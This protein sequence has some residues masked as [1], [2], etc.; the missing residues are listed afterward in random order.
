VVVVLGLGPA[1]VPVPVQAQVPA[2]GQALAQA[3]VLGLA[4]APVLGQAL[5]QVP[6]D[7]F[8][9]GAATSRRRLLRIR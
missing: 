7:C 1:Q 5:A 9:T 3:P 8:R 2:R 4:Q 6:A